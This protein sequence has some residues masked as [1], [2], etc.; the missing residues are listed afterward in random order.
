MDESQTERTSWRKV[1]IDKL[2]KYRRLADE[3]RIIRDI[4]VKIMPIIISSSGA[5]HKKSLDVFQS[6]CL[7]EHKIMKK[8][9]RRLSE[10]AIIGSMEIWRG[11]AKDMRYEESIRI[12]QMAEQE[13]IVINN[14]MANQDPEIKEQEDAANNQDEREDEDG[15]SYDLTDEIED[16]TEVEEED[17]NIHCTEEENEQTQ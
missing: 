7:C 10:A 12:G 1:Y 17:R 3:T 4:Y 13:E 16:E 15:I 11:H 8:L 6:L 14:E 2:E 5:V 9:R